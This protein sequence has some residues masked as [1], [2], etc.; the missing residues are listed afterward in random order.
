MV[1]WMVRLELVHEFEEPITHL[2]QVI[3]GQV[4]MLLSAMT[5]CSSHRP[6]Y[7]NFGMV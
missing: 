5:S 1:R 2:P 6:T 7:L 3:R 4:A